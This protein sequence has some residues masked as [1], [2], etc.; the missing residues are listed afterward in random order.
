MERAV[1]SPRESYAGSI[2]IAGDPSSHH[3]S[4]S[5]FASSGVLCSWPSL[6]L[7]SSH[8]GTYHCLDSNALHFLGCCSS[9]DYSVLLSFSAWQVP[10]C[11]F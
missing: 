2:S 4:A 11:P 3:P 7:L 1:K 6:S 8:L 10:L 5:I 9:P